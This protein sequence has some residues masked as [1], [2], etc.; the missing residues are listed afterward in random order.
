MSP[1]DRTSDRL[2][3]ILEGRPIGELVRTPRGLR[4][5]YDPSYADDANLV[6]GS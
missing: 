3:V 5:E 6:H 1:S 4:M 2:V